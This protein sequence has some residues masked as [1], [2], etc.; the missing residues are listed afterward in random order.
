MSRVL[1]GRTADRLVENERGWGWLTLTRGQ[2]V[3]QRLIVQDANQSS[4]MHQTVKHS[5]VSSADLGDARIRIIE[6][7]ATHPKRKKKVTH[8]VTTALKHT[9]MEATQSLGQSQGKEKEKQ[10]V[11]NPTCS[12]HH[13]ADVVKWR[14]VTHHKPVVRADRRA[15]LEKECTALTIVWSL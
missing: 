3:H 14:C 10:L 15:N 9:R 4:T 1:T 2:V 7:S 12:L 11:K 5:S 8:T 6:S 13:N